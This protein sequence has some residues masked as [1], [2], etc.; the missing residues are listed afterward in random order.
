MALNFTTPIELPSGIELLQAYG[1]VSVVDN[2]K[3]DSIQTVV[4]VFKSEQDFV[5]GKSTIS[6]PFKCNA[7]APYD[8]NV[9]GVDVLDIAHDILIV[10]LDKQGYVATKSL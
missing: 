7:S 10:A 4:D 2:Y 9:Q 5:D 1:R 3:G 8:R 6:M